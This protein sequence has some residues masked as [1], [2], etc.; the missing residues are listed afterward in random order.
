MDLNVS[1]C[2]Y[3]SLIS[4][5]LFGDPFGGP[6]LGNPQYKKLITCKGAGRAKGPG[7][8]GKVRLAEEGKHGP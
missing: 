1:L 4:S 3:P 2:V 8:A 5:G 7:Q 6:F